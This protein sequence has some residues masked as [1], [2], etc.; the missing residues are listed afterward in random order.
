MTLSVAKKKI[1]IV[2]MDGLGD[3]GCKELN[4]LTPLQAT[5]TPNLDWFTKN[6]IAGTCDTVAPGIRPGSDTS[7]LSILSYDPLKVYTGRGPFEAAG[8]GLIGKPGDVAF[9]CNFST[10]DENMIIT[11]RRAGRITTPDTTELMKALSGMV[12]DGIEVI[13]KESTEHRAAMILRGPGLNP[14]VTDV[15]S[16]DSGPFNWCKGKVPEAEFTAEVVN[17]FVKESYSRLKD[18]PVNKRRAGEGLI[19]ANIILPRGAG[20]FPDIQPFPKKYEISAACVAGVGMIKGICGVCGLDVIELPSCCTGGCGSDFVS[21]AA[22]AMK[23]L[24][25]YDFILMNA[26]APDVCGHDRDPLLKCEII[27]KLDAMAGYF[28]ENFRDDL[29]I[30]FTA[31]HSTP[32]SL[33]DHSGDPVPITIYTPGNVMDDA[34]TFSESGCAHGR[35]GRIRGKC[36][37]PICM[38]LAERVEKFGA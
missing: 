38:D 22:V 20:A 31:D 30:V 29:V 12:I 25:K 18:H 21:K 5:E 9:R 10:A 3:R 13:I 11:D 36:I 14:N 27:K 32:C 15:D 28:R 19:P 34:T 26:K 6:G 33:G 16:H 2:V 8:I 17:K 37:V 4:G 23:T 1:L 24:E 35:I 7:H